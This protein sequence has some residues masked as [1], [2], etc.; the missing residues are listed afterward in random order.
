MPRPVLPAALLAAALLPAAASAA[1][2]S[3]SATQVDYAGGAGD[4][5]SIGVYGGFDDE[6]RTSGGL[7]LPD[8]DRHRRPDHERPDCVARPAGGSS[9]VARPRTLIGTAGQDDFVNVGAAGDVDRA[10][11]GRRR[12]PRRSR[13]ARGSRR[14][15][16]PANDDLAGYTGFDILDGG[17]GD[18]QL[19]AVR[20]G[21]QVAGGAGT[22]T[23][24]ATAATP[25]R[26]SSRSTAWRTTA[27]PA[28]ARTSP[29]T[30]RTSP[31][32]AARTTSPATRSANTLR[33]GEGGD[34]LQ[35]GGGADSCSA[36]AG[37]TS[38]RAR[39]GVA[40][41]VDCGPGRTRSSS[42]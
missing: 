24:S 36:R 28:R 26:W 22:S 37:T 23:R 1:T 11:H 14:T 12:R 42:T 40:D 18:D 3:T 21:D 8:R 15:A 32:A 4:R 2:I 30:S 41:T 19:V 5:V 27:R 34:T 10:A 17:A 29:R 6:L 35:G 7:L 16:R 20:V 25:I 38:I 9:C 39:D 33:G 31:A 13:P